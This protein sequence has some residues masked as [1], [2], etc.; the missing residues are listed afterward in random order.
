VL[1]KIIRVFVEV[2][3]Y[4][5]RH[6]LFALEES[7]PPSDDLHLRVPVENPALINLD[8]PLPSLIGVIERRKILTCTQINKNNKSKSLSDYAQR[9]LSVVTRRP[10]I[11]D[12]QGFK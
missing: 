8:L 10:G 3:V 4:H 2:F 12:M 1:Q 7:G 6:T 5:D 11:L 9:D